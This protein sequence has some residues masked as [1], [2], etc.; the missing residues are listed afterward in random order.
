[1]RLEL[2]ERRL[3]KTFLNKVT[4]RALLGRRTASKVTFWMGEAVVV[5]VVGGAVTVVAIVVEEVVAGVAVEDDEVTPV[6]EF[7]V[8]VEEV[9]E[10][11]EDC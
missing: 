6:V 11:V 2:T 8:A 10:V 1:M 7:G 3:E 4:L 5:V 9:R